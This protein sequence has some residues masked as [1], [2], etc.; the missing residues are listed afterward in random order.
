MKGRILSSDHRDVGLVF[1]CHRVFSRVL[2]GLRR[3]PCSDVAACGAADAAVT[4][5]ATR[6]RGAGQFTDRATMRLRYLKNNII[7]RSDFEKKNRKK[8]N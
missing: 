8:K 3:V 2:Q 6:Q 5:L 1:R 4:A 7:A